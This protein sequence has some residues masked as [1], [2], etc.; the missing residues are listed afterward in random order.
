[1]GVRHP[2]RAALSR[3]PSSPQNPPVNGGGSTTKVCP[4]I[5]FSASHADYNLIEKRNPGLPDQIH[6]ELSPVTGTFASC[7]HVVAGM[8]HSSERSERG[9]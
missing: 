2:L 9:S 5:T 8:R 6:A 1:M 7:G 3:T 4:S